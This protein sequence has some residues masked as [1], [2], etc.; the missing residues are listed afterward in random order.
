MG[1]EFEVE[2]QAGEKYTAQVLISD[3]DPVITLGKL[4]NQKI[5]P[6]KIKKKVQSLR[7][8]IGAFYAFIGTDL[9]L[10]SLGITDA[11]IH[12]YD[13]FDI[14]KI[15]SSQNVANLTESVPWY[16][17][18]SPSVKDPT[19]GH[20]PQNHHI[21]EILT[22]IGHGDF[23]NWAHAP[24]MKRGEEYEQLKEQIGHCL[25]KGAERHIPGLTKHL[26]YIEYATPL[27]N[28]SW[29]NSVG[30]GCYG[31][32]QTPDQFGPGRF[33]Q[34]TAGIEGL[35]LTGAG[36]LGGGVMACVTSGY[37]AAGKTADFLG[38]KL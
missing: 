34:F 32:E 20:A 5:V 33:S 2:T 25:V 4:V 29:V 16:F 11:N 38:L 36:T 13:D 17:I 10:P 24:S 18:T 35:F 21:V 1:N 12:H 9:D 14:N 26:K 30:G 15:F 6:S 31:P 8:S 28:E 19:G 7:P 22:F 23:E 3:A 27:S 37:L